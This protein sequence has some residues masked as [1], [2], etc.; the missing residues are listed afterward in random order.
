LLRRIPQYDA[1]CIEPDEHD[2]AA[3]LDYIRHTDTTAV[4]M[5]ARAW[6]VENNSLERYAE[7]WNGLLDSIRLPARS[8]V[9]T[10]HGYVPEAK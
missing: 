5:R 8:G 1:L 7:R 2:L 10:G 3:K 9:Q 4:A 6:V